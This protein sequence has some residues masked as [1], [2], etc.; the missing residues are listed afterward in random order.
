MNILVLTPYIP[1][2]PNF[3]GSVRIFHLIR[4]L[5]RLGHTTHLLSFREEAGVGDPRGL[6]PFCK[7]ITLIPRVIG[8]KR[9][10]QFASLFSSRSFQWRFHDSM[11]MQ[12]ALNRLV[13][14]QHIQLILVEF[15]QMAGFSFP[16][17]IPV[18]LDEH[19]VEFD[20]LD[21]MA[22]REGGALRK[23]F[24]RV[25]ARKFRREELAACRAV[26]M[27]LVTSERDGQLLESH[28]P[29]LQ[30]TVI[31]NGVDCEHFRRP[32][33]L[34]QPTSGVFVG[35]T[36]YFP[37]EDGVVFFL[38]EVLPLIQE[39]QP[40]FRFTVVGGRPPSSIVQYESATV[41]VT[42][43]VGDVRPFMW[44]S[45]VFV[46]PLRMGGGTRFKIVEAFA[47][48]IPV[49]STRLGAEGIPAQ[50]G[51]ELLLA[52]APRDLAAAVLRVLENPGL[53]DGLAQAG[54]EFVRRHFDWSVIGDK[55][56]TTLETVVSRK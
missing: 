5:H 4:Q 48:G 10:Q 44:E 11:T 18:V 21:R 55:L 56:N 38:R 19:N 36:H 3:G 42:G 6:E 23:W 7:T 53:A 50:D 49:V 47:A 26:A 2:P 20:L 51:R 32:A 31:T 15:S 33:G 16:A 29:G 8:N 17:D 46:V 54:A 24:N 22:I 9:G 37:N 25:E 41:E 34:R 35:A 12:A 45:S 30:T 52:D 14:E 28:S 39:K 13:R 40:R 27:T 43:Y 1:Y